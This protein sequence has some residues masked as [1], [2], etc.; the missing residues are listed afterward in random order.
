VTEWLALLASA[1]FVAGLLG[2]VHCAA[3]CGGIVA[4]CASGGRHRTFAWRRTLAY[5]A[6]R[7]SSYVVAGAIAGAAGQIGLALRGGS[8]VHHVLLLVA[9]ISLVV[10]ALYVGGATRIVRG[11]ERIGGFVWRYLQPYS[12]AFLPAD[13]PARALGLGLLWG[14]LPCGMVYAVLMTAVAT[15]DA[16]QGALVMLAFGG[17][18]LPNLIGVAYAAGRLR[19]PMK[20]PALRIAAAATIALIGVTALAG[21]AGAH[22][23]AFDALFCLVPASTPLH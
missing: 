11:M 20:E 21:A 19:A 6:G 17:G 14:W 15:G 23:S 7:I 12:R 16:V 13:T 5:N 4:A 10:V 8:A 2:G 3:M 9:G 1:A 22:L 18:T